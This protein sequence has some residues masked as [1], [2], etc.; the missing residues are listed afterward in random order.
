[1]LTNYSLVVVPEG[2][3]EYTGIGTGP[4]R[5][6]Q[7]S[8]GEVLEAERFED[9]FRADTKAHV[10]TV[11]LIGVNDIA[12]RVSAIQTGQVHI[13]TQLDPRSAELLGSLPTLEIVFLRGPGFSGINMMLDKPPF[14]NLQ[15]RQALKYAIDREDI[16]ARV[17]GGFARLGNDTPVPPNSADF[18]ADV[19]QYS[20]DP[21]RARALYEESGHS[22]PITLQ[23]SE[24]AGS[25]AVDIATLF[26]EHAA[27]AGIEIEIVREPADGYWSNVWAATPFHSTL[28]G[29]RAT[30]EMIL[31]IAYGSGSPANDT[32]FSSPEFDAALDRARSSEDRADQLVA[33]AEAQRVLAETGGAIIP[34]F[35]D[36]PE[37]VSTDLR[38]YVPGTLL[39]GSTRAAEN[40]WFA[41]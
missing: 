21:E 22:G 9:Y 38:G 31:S 24:A 16:I 36:I 34:A 27:Q 7:F 15:L 35:G 5:I 14:D 25:A 10:D 30:S 33:L 3:T 2:T 12:A 41:T 4:Y 29:A 13:A 6:T 26:R 1:M 19:P 11:T 40:V 39:V 37:G 20:Y 17:Y 32:A 18:A 23:T 8:P 28:W